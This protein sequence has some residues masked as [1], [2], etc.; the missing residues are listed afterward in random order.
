MCTANVK[1]TPTA[2]VYIFLKIPS[3]SISEH[4]TLIGAHHKPLAIVYILHADYA[5]HNLLICLTNAV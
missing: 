2:I 1:I 4:A 5:K 3:D